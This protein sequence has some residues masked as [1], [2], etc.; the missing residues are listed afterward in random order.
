MTRPSA[1]LALLLVALAAQGC[2]YIDVLRTRSEAERLYREGRTADIIPLVESALARVEGS[3]GPDHRYVAEAYN[4]LAILYAQSLNDFQRSEQY[5]QKAL[6][7]RTRTLG[8]EHPDTI[9]TLNL[10][11]FLY[12]V[13]GDLPRA[14][15][16]FTRALAL[17]TKVLGPT[18]PDTADS[19]IFLAG[20]Y[21]AQGRYPEAQALYQEASLHEQQAVS[22]RHPSPGNALAGLG[23]V[24][25]A[26]GDRDGAERYFEE[27][28]A[29]REQELG[30]DHTEVAHLLGALGD[31]EQ[32]A[33]DDAAAEIYMLRKLE[34]HERNFGPDHGWTGDSLLQL[35]MLYAKT[36]RN[37]EADA[38]L[39]RSQGVY[40]RALGPDNPRS[41][42]AEL[43]FALLDLR[44]GDPGTARLRCERVLASPQL[45]QLGE[46]TWASQTVYSIALWKLGQTEPAILFGKQAVNDIQARRARIAGLDPALQQGFALQREIAFKS[47]AQQLIEQGRLPEAQQ[48]LQMLKEDEYFG[49]IRRDA[50]RSSALD[51]RVA[52]TPREE[53][54]LA[55][56]QQIGDRLAALGAELAERRRQRKLGL[57]AADDPRLA[58][59]REDMKVAQAAFRQFLEELGEE[60]ERVPRARAVEIGQKNLDELR[61]MQGTLRDLG[62]GAVLVHTLIT[63]DTLFLIVTTGEA[64]L[65]RRSEIP[66]AELHRRIHAFRQALQDPR[67]DPRPASQA[68]H[69]VLLAPIAADLR[70]AK[71]RTLMF[72]MD[73]ALRY[74]PPAALYDG[75]RYVVEDYGVVL[76]TES[77]QT[78]LTTPPAEDWSLAGLG[79]THAVEGFDQLPGVE[80]E[81]EKIVRHGPDDGRRGA[82]RRDPPRRRVHE[83]AHG[84]GAGR[85]LPG[86]PHRQPLRVP[87]RYG[88]R[89]L[90]PA[91]RR[92]QA[93]PRAHRR[94]QLRLRRRGPAHPLGLRHRHGQQLGRRARDRGLRLAGPAPGREGRP[95]HTLAGGRREHQPSHGAALREPSKPFAR[96]GRGAAPLAA[97]AAARQR[98]RC[99]RSREHQPA[100]PRPSLLLGALH[101]HG[102]LALAARAMPGDRPAGSRAGGR[103]PPPRARRCAAGPRRPAPPARGCP[104]SRTRRGCAGPRDR[105]S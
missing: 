37:E 19:Q 48:V 93:Q 81:L 53:P 44:R 39:R 3:L 12:Q 67:F 30:P 101:P 90:P 14:E 61:A 17:R 28:L 43:A 89:L 36:D 62:H 64:Q 100:A 54:W 63:D 51:T 59:L 33:G 42:N 22:T 9:E 77:A 2:V 97:G 60:L 34:I 8:P 40:E 96:Q 11:G 91:G 6:G 7:I 5:F 68:L 38:F 71:A 55:R 72:S 65:V 15:D 32:E 41:L 58:E 24:H 57:V 95:G 78:R 1:L 16:H 92:R 73:G 66:S 26:L 88:A 76:F 13:T 98:G 52:A 87:A 82:S 94:G 56:Y 21:M 75:E 50:G 20:L 4:G 74:V 27:A 80:T 103:T 99:P 35:A 47:L 70:Q 102:Q 84:R 105:W 10:M 23:A 31:L 46:L 45:R 104:S 29:L 69:E 79:L 86:D 83:R 49:F 18:H 25:R 85:R